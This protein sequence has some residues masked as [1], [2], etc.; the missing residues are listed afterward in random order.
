M[1]SKIIKLLEDTQKE[2]IE[3]SGGSSYFIVNGEKYYT[4][5]TY[6]LDGIGL[7]IDIIKNKLSVPC[8]LCEQNEEICKKCGNRNERKSTY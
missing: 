1:K 3:S 6:A 2:L 5:T 4:D 7:F 8:S